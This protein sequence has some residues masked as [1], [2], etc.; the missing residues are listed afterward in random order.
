MSARLLLWRASLADRHVTGCQGWG[1]WVAGAGGSYSIRSVKR[2]AVALINRAPVVDAALRGWSRWNTEE[3]D[4]V[5]PLP[6]LLGGEAKLLERIRAAG[7]A[8]SMT[9]T[10]WRSGTT[11][12]GR[13]H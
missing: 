3:L 6:T 10:H 1:R 5:L 4:L 2:G 9:G 7:G 12:S 13:W 8:L 11:P